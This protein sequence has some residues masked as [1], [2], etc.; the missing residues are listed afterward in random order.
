[1]VDATI[2][3]YLLNVTT[4]EQLEMLLID[5]VTIYLYD[6]LN[7]DIFMKIPEGFK[8]PEGH[9]PNSRELYSIK[10]CISLYGLKQAGCM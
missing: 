6:S 1:M 8:L 3:C 9:D 2:F 5:V 4:N 10:L 7:N